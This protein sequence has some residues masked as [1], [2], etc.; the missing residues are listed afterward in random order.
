MREIKFRGKDIIT[1]KWL[2]GS[3]IYQPV[4]A[5]CFPQ[6][7]RTP[8]KET[9]TRIYL[10]ETFDDAAK[11]CSVDPDT[12]GQYTGLKDTNGVEIYEGDI[13][14]R[15]NAQFPIC[16]P[17]DYE[18]GAFYFHDEELGFC[19]CPLHSIAYKTPTLD[20]LEVVGNIHDNPELLK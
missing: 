5:C 19:S 6:D 16:G 13:L 1:G 12:V 3:Y 8:P 4:F 17:V 20:E 11:I 9:A 14:C 15:N 10:P 7:G 18:N 2:Y